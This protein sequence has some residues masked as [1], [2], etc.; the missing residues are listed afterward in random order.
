MYTLPTPPDRLAELAPELLELILSHLNPRDLTT[1][2]STCQ[3]A[4]A[5]VHPNNKLLWRAA[6]LHVFDD[7]K[8]AWSLLLP[9]ARAENQDCELSWDWHRE[10]HRRY[11]AFNAVCETGNGALLLAGPEQV[12][13]SLLHVYDTASY[14]MA[15]DTEEPVSLNVDFLE[16][17]FR[18]APDAEKVVHDY[19]R[20]IESM[21]LPLEF[22]FEDRPITRSMLNRKTIVPE[23]AS[24]FHAFYGMTKREDESLRSKSSARALV[25]D[26]SVT[27][28]NA[29]YGPLTKDGSGTVN[30]QTLEA[31]ASLMHRIFNN[32]KG[33]KYVLPS[34]FRSHIPYSLTPDSVHPEDWAGI[35]R[36]WVGTYAFLDYRALV[37]YNFANNIEYPLDLGAYEE[38]SGDLMR[39][40]LQISDDEEL[41]KDFRLESDLP[42]CKDLPKLYFEGHSG[43]RPTGRLPIQV[44]GSACLISGA[45]QVRWRFIIR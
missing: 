7:P 13:T 34:G 28:A 11:T 17:L 36:M 10:V 37:H 35:T 29:D 12:V 26:W 38:A 15:L 25:Y 32:T 30:W 19:H 8:A 41:R 42:Y 16:R 6:F 44:R 14:S 1:F 18:T 39:L 20:D 4:R 3:R 24:R 21:S 27:S 43:G 22:M 5:F 23:W 31:I 45:R 2:G 40:Q 9:T 33:S